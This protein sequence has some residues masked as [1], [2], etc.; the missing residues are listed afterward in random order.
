MKLSVPAL[1]SGSSYSHP[2]YGSELNGQ[3]GYVSSMDDWHTYAV[4]W[5]EDCMK[6]FLDGNC[7]ETITLTSDM[8]EEFHKPHFILLNLAIGSTSTPFTK[9]T[10][11]TSDWQ[12]SSMYVD[13]VRVY[14]GSDG[15]FYR[16]QT[17][18]TSNIQ[19]TASP[20]AGMT[21]CAADGWYGAGSVWD[22]NFSTSWAQA[23]GYYAGG[24][25]NDFTIYISNPSLYEWGSMIR[26]R[27]GVTPGHSYNYTINYTSNNAG[28]ALVKEDVS[29]TG[30]QTVE[31][32]QAA[33]Q[34][35]A[36]LRQEIPR[37]KRRFLWI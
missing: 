28:S 27:Q 14:Q 15:N 18:D 24:S 17:S 10:T 13:Y 32:L 35:V 6:F 19:T 37:R 36:P 22:Y 30:D 7:Y 2:Y 23:S 4:E 1:N 21:A 26:A 11:V 20:T 29:L 34:S 12:T 8:A 16:A 9:N 33:E 25:Q 31:L 3:Y 5:Y